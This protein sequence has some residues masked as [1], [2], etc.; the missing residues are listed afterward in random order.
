MPSIRILPDKVVNQIAA[1]EVIERPASVVKELVEN[2]LDAG[3]TRIEVEFR[4]AGKNY[5]RIEDNGCGM[6]S[7]EALLS[8]ERYAT[9]KLVQIEDLLSIHSFGFRGEALPSIA[10]ISRMTIKT[11]RKQDPIGTEIL[12][13]AGKII[14]RIDCGMAPGTRIE[15]EHLFNSVPSR[16]AFLKTDNTEAAHITH[17]CRLYAVANPDVSF[18]LIE[19]GNTIFKSPKCASLKDRIGEIW[20]WHLVKELIEMNPI[21]RGDMKI[22]GVLGKPSVSRSTRLEMVTLVNNRP[23]DSRTLNSAILE[24][25]HGYIPKGRYPVVF[26]FLEVTPSVVDVNV[27]PAKRE[28]RF[29][30]EGMIREFII[31]SV[32][33]RLQQ[34]LKQ[35][36]TPWQNEG[37][38]NGNNA[39]S[40]ST[41]NAENTIAASAKIE[42]ANAAVPSVPRPTVTPLNSPVSRTADLHQP[43]SNLQSKETQ[44]SSAKSVVTPTATPA[45]SEKSAMDGLRPIT[46]QQFQDHTLSK[47]ALDSAL[48][49]TS[50]SA[51][52]PISHQ[53]KTASSNW[54]YLGRLKERWVLFKSQAGLVVMDIQAAWQRI[55]YESALEDVLHNAQANRNQQA[56]LI[57]IPLEL[58]ALTDA[59][60]KD[61]M[62]FLAQQG[63][64]IEL[65]GRNF[66]RIE[67]VPT[68]INIEEAEGFIRDFLGLLRE[69]SLSLSQ[70]QLLREPIARLVSQS[71]R[72]D[73][74]KMNNDPEIIGLAQDLLKCQQPLSCPKGKP[75]LFEVSFSD[76][77]RHFGR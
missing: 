22:K 17:L 61:A 73:W 24:S 27:H 46:P 53:P 35:S 1:G 31:T 69:K 2:S 75:T 37:T 39:N 3:A 62:P 20:G 54:D 57:P 18:V 63:F 33:E 60:M 72:G 29:R 64:K 40:A 52:Q 7:D 23:V 49:S 14:H 65:F 45:H 76:L 48:Q 41:A 30:Q 66:Y 43:A 21:D 67:S 55:R 38:S 74:K 28:V 13:N 19:N 11:R 71:T 59:V 77:D 56:L 68:W 42:T 44:Q 10:S 70:P 26:L 15:V 50:Q 16:R 9:S 6:S 32:H 25:Y 8:L 36:M 5:I 34:F 47:S 12:I 4:Q 58:D 51:S